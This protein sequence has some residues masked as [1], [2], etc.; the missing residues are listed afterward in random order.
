[1]I[2]NITYVLTSLVEEIMHVSRMKRLLKM[3]QIVH[4]MLEYK[5]DFVLYI[6]LINTGRLN[7]QDVAILQCTHFQNPRLYQT[8]CFLFLYF[9]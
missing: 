2:R 7:Q 9:T 5:T 8:K 4:N 6:N 1:M 3:Q